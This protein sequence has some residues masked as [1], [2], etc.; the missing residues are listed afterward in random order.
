M[1]PKA[2]GGNYPNRYYY[3]AFRIV[4]NFVILIMFPTFAQKGQD[5]L[6]YRKLIIKERKP[7]SIIGRATSQIAEKMAVR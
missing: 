5:H 1:K 2:Q 3:P 4:W 7:D 6:C